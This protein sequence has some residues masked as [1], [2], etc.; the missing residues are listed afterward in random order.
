MAITKIL[1]VEDEILIAREMQSHLHEMGHEVVGI[2]LDSDTA[3]KQVAETLPDLM[4]MDINLPGALDG[5]AIAAKVRDHFQIPVVY[6]TALSGAE[7]S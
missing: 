6:V 4:L 3:L 2:A 1:I 5:I 7:N